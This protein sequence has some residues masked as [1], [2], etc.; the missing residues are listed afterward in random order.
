ME[1]GLSEAGGA[2]KFPEVNASTEVNLAA[3]EEFPVDPI[4]SNVATA[5]ELKDE[6]E[7]RAKEKE[8]AASQKCRLGSS[9]MS[10]LVI[11]SAVAAAIGVG[12]IVIKK[13]K[14]T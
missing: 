12:F 2:D 8:A 4:S 10:A 14:T 13:S 5:K 11:S 9:W 7:A 6:T 3:P 1:G